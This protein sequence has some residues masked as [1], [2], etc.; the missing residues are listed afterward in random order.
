MKKNLSDL[1]W[2]DFVERRTDCV[3]LDS[4]I[5]SHPKVWEASGHVEEFTD[6]LTECG[7]CQQRVRADHLLETVLSPQDV[8]EMSMKGMKEAI[9]EHGIVCPSCGAPSHKLGEPCEYNLL[10]STTLGATA[11]PHHADDTSAPPANV[12]YLR[13]ETAQGAYINF[14]QVV[15]STRKR[16]PFGIGQIGKAFRN[17]IH[18]SNFLFRTREF[19]LMELQ[20]F[21]HP[22]AAAEAYQEWTR[23]CFDWLRKLG[24]EENRLRLREY[25]PGE[26]AHYATATADIE[27]D[28]P[29]LGW[30]ELWGI[31]N[32]GDFDLNRHMQGCNG[33]RSVGTFLDPVTNE[34]Y[35]PHVV[36]PALGLNRA[37]LAL[38][39][40]A[41]T[42]E[43]AAAGQKGPGRTVLR[44][45]EDIAPYK[46]AVLPLM[47]KGGM[48]EHAEGL[49]GDLLSNEDGGYA[50]DF[51][52][53][54]SIGK[55]YRRQDEV[56]T[57]VCITVDQETLQNGTVTA[58]CRDTQAQ[59]RVDQTELLEIG[60][61]KRLL[62]KVRG[63]E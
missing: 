42:E 48:L 25:G 53:T 63:A 32:R 46:V 26:V 36:E 29:S 3:G 34:R 61:Y 35:V 40:D 7:K 59:V 57:P 8:A 9:V 20:Y 60:G 41:Y 22:D 28:F 52:A 30:S 31:A 5:V 45:H 6:P 39:S 43:E 33:D 10:F 21:C 27:Y 58:R 11:A 38:L 55:R 24:V 4:S 19:E 49:W 23:F 47:K 12:A 13:P 1:W 37:M 16:I 54:G 15:S 44:L 50:A 14:S 17:E 62:E 18:P 56:G 2:K 51:D